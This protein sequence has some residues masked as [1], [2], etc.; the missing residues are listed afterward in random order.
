MNN[1]TVSACNPRWI[2][3][4]P[5]R[6]LGKRMHQTFAKRISSLR[7]DN[8]GSV[9]L[10]ELAHIALHIDTGLCDAIVESLDEIS[11][12]ELKMGLTR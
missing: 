9:L 2:R 6:V 8:F 5:V 12:E 10:D 4:V 3:T 7:L 1:G 11:T